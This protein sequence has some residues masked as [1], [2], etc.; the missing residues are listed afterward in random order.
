MTDV[1]SLGTDVQ[2]A[3]EGE[4]PGY[5]HGLS[6]VDGEQGVTRLHCLAVL[7]GDTADLAG[8]G[9]RNCL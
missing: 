3:V 9:R 4:A 1:V 2:L 8:G 7:H 5:G 6:A